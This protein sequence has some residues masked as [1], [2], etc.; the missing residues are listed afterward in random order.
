MKKNKKKTIGSLNIMSNGISFTQ[1]S[2]NPFSN[3]LQIV[4]PSRDIDS[5]K[6][7][8]IEGTSVLTVNSKKGAIYFYGDSIA[9]IHNA[10]LETLGVKML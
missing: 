2:L 5:Y 3:L 1:K 6:T 4:L 8:V 9:N 10:M 7:E